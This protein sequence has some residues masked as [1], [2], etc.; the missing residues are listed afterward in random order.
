MS[1]RRRPWVLFASITLNNFSSAIS[2]LSL[3][4][5]TYVLMLLLLLVSDLFS[6][7]AKRFA[8]TG[9]L[10]YHM[11][12][13]LTK[14]SPSISEGNVKITSLAWVVFCSPTYYYCPGFFV[15]FSEQ[16]LKRTDGWR[17]DYPPDRYT[18]KLYGD[19]L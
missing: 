3:L 18:H 6:F 16:K 13:S 1:C 12:I 17:L 14:Y 19:S 10:P 5:T 4:V 11:L 7:D 8:Y 2:H 9:C 15:H